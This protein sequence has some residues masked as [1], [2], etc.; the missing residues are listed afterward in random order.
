MEQP[1]IGQRLLA[2]FAQVP[3]PRSRHGL[4]HRL[5]AVLALGARYADTPRMRHDK[6]VLVHE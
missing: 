6:E 4:R 2:A 5:P 3:D 1:E